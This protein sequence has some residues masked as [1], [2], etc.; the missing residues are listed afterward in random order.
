MQYGPMF[1]PTVDVPT[2]VT[3][4]TPS[5]ETVPGT[6][7]TSLSGEFSKGVSRG[8]DLIQALGYGAAGLTAD[9]F[10]NKAAALDMYK[11]AQGQFE[12]MQ[13]ANQA[14]AIQSY[15]DVDSMSKFGQYA[16]GVVGEQLPMTAVTMLTGGISTAIARLGLGITV[17]TALTNPLVQRSASKVVSSLVAKGMSQES[18]EQVAKGVVVD[19]F[20]KRAALVG[21][22]GSGAA[23]EGGGTWIEDVN[24][25]GVSDTRPG[26]DTISGLV[27]GGIETMFGPEAMMAGAIG[28]RAVGKAATTSAKEFL[29]RAALETAKSGAGEP[30]EEGLQNVSSEFALKYGRPEQSQ[31][32][33]SKFM[34]QTG[35]EMAAAGVAGTV[36]GLLGSPMQVR[37]ENM[38]ARQQDRLDKA[39]PESVNM[40]NVF[41]EELNKVRQ[42]LSSPAETKMKAGEEVLEQIRTESEQKLTDIKSNFEPQYQKVAKDVEAVVTARAEALSSGNEEM[43]GRLDEQLARLIAQRSSIQK[44]YTSELS[45]ATEEAKAASNKAKTAIVKA[46]QDYVKEMNDPAVV[47]KNKQLQTEAPIS[48]EHERKSRDFLSQIQKGI[49]TQ[50]DR[51]YSRYDQLTAQQ[52]E[53][54]AMLNNNSQLG[55]VVTPSGERLGTM[56]FAEEAELHKQID[57]IDAIKEREVNRRNKIISL[58]EELAKVMARKGGQLENMPAIRKVLDELDLISDDRITPDTPLLE[59]FTLQQKAG[60]QRGPQ[61]IDKSAEV[62]ESRVEK[63]NTAWDKDFE[64]AWA[65]EENKK[66][67]EARRQWEATQEYEDE[68]LRKAAEEYKQQ[69][70]TKYREEEKDYVTPDNLDQYGTRPN[71]PSRNPQAV[72]EAQL[73]VEQMPEERDFGPTK[74]QRTSVAYEGGSTPTS[75]VMTLSPQYKATPFPQVKAWVDSVLKKLPGLAPYVVLVSDRVSQGIPSNVLGF[76]S[77][78][79]KE[80]GKRVPGVFDVNTSKIYIFSDRIADKSDFMRVLMHEAVGHLGLRMIF[81]STKA[82][83]NFM[84]MIHS[85]FKDTAEWKNIITNSAYSKRSDIEQA[86]EFFAKMAERVKVENILRKKP[87]G[88]WQKFIN[89]IEQIVKKFG[90]SKVTKEDLETVIDGIVLGYA[91]NLEVTEPLRTSSTQQFM[92]SIKKSETRAAYAD[93][94]DA[95]IRAELSEDRTNKFFTRIPISAFLNLTTESA[96]HKQQ[97][98]NESPKRSNIYPYDEVNSSYFDPTEFDLEGGFAYPT[99]A[100]DTTDGKVVSHE[101]RHRAA[102]IMKDGGTTVPVLISLHGPDA[103]TVDR[104]PSTLVGQYTQTTER[105]P[106]AIKAL[107]SNFDAIKAEVGQT[108]SEVFAFLDTVQDLDDN[109]KF[110][111][112][113]S[114]VDTVREKLKNIAKQI[115]PTRTGSDAEGNLKDSNLISERGIELFA[116]SNRRVEVFIKYVSEK[117]GKAVISFKNNLSKHLETLGNRTDAAHHD[118]ARQ[119]EAPL[120]DAIVNVALPNEDI[121]TT[122]K[123]CDHYLVCKRWPEYVRSLLNNKLAAPLRDKIARLEKSHEKYGGQMYNILNKTEEGTKVST[124]Q[125]LEM[126]ELQKKMHRIEMTLDK[127]RDQY[128]RM[129]DELSTEEGIEKF[130]DIIGLQMSLKEANDF[131]EATEKSRP[132]IKKV[133][134]IFKLIDMQ[135]IEM[136]RELKILHPEVLDSIAQNDFYV[137]FKQWDSLVDHVDPMIKKRRG[138]NVGNWKAMYVTRGSESVPVDVMLGT[139]MQAHDTIDMMYR[140]ETGRMI[141]ELAKTMEELG[142]PALK[143]ARDAPT[144]R[145]LVK[146]IEDPAERARILGQLSKQKLSRSAATGEFM[147]TSTKKTHTLDGEKNI[148]KLFDENGDIVF[149]QVADDKLAQVLK[150]E[151]MINAPAVI[152]FIGKMTRAM[153]LM[154]TS[155]NPDFILT[156]QI[157][158]IGSAIFHSPR[159]QYELQNHGFPTLNS[160]IA[161]FSKHLGPSRK[162]V[163]DWLRNKPGNTEY[164]KDFALMRKYGG[165]SE[166]YGQGTFETQK[167]DFDTSL[168]KMTKQGAYKY[169]PWRMMD[170]AFDYLDNLSSSFE[171]STRLA[172][173]KTVANAYISDFQRKHPTATAKEMNEVT[174]QAYKRAA[175]VALNITINFTKRGTLSSW[176][177]P[178]YMFF[179]ASVNGN[180]N[181]VRTITHLWKNDKAKFYSMLGTVTTGAFLLSSLCRAVAGKDDDGLYKYD[182]LPLWRKCMFI[183]IPVPLKG[184]GVQFISIPLPPGP[185]ILWAMAICSDA[186]LNGAVS[187]GTAMSELVSQTMDTFNPLGGSEQPWMMIIPSIARPFAQVAI[188]ENAFGHKIYPE[189]KFKEIPDSEKHWKSVSVASKWFTSMVNKAF[190]GNESKPGTMLGLDMSF[191]PE[192]IDHVLGSLFGGLGRTAMRVVDMAATMSQGEMPEV[193]KIP[194]IRRFLT[195]EDKYATTTLYNQITKEVQMG[196]DQIENAKKLNLGSTEI[197]KRQTENKLAESMHSA[198]LD[199]ENK[200]QKLK[201]KSKEISLSKI[202]DSAKQSQSKLVDAQIK[203]LQVQLIKM[204]ER[205]GLNYK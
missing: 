170:T 160:F 186:A 67:E 61:P 37:R 165:F 97:I 3:F 33:D 143:I 205:K 135:R 59:L 151:H 78:M 152:K 14:A 96:E 12:E 72:I 10:G 84:N 130:S 178:L 20:M 55:S 1:T 69:E 89:F 204:A 46:K 34:S 191:S 158:D 15:K 39:T 11:G 200:I 27:S 87:E 175:S 106:H 42:E 74:A 123:V 30:V 119:F 153:A 62:T 95:K 94:S 159:F 140:I 9:L 5:Q 148:L 70:L 146:G 18:A 16:M 56:S 108:D 102:L 138:F 188:N 101:G 137:S 31:M 157:R 162:A 127:K 82:Y 121:T 92:P 60:E 23:M 8:V 193:E 172:I 154:A 145:Q 32:F 183:N 90:F 190:G 76:V 180:I 196:H 132:E 110:L 161:E 136:L 52:H 29:G 26:A 122:R 150:G 43:A 156:N 79:E 21:M 185:H 40:T 155:R 28:K 171:N 63:Q 142:D 167:K 182:K 203:A 147:V 36:F 174:E 117:Y 116:D 50:I 166:M 111:D 80:T 22:T 86:E 24:Q 115:I 112:Q 163:M 4:A 51:S 109:M 25:H 44:S 41:N 124:K 164:L 181:L 104:I 194:V 168:K 99:L 6:P 187:A 192:T 13:A 77:R 38:I 81:D 129:M 83:T 35:E 125:E 105:A 134:D 144:V 177:S 98:I 128:Q 68:F 2:G 47:Q 85:S 120:Y 64:T 198:T 149:V 100:I 17:E 103:R 133:S 65:R 197:R 88:I 49:D 114:M 71:G 45:A 131:V 93:F 126:S 139:L 19:Q 53:L 179:G 195:D 48:A 7:T 66:K 199:I 141:I 201:T 173:F 73:P 75:T 57:A 169:L 91:Q 58:T 54:Y 184:I 107:T 118:F 113:D 176:L 189:S 202:S